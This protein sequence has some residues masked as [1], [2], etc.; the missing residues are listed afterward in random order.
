MRDLCQR[1]DQFARWAEDV[2]PPVLFWLSGFTF[3]NGF[4]AAVLQSTARQQRISVDTLSWEFIVSTVDDRNLLTPPEDGVY[5]RGLYLEGAGWDRKNSCLVEAEPMQMV[6][7]FP[8]IYFKPVE[9][10]KM[11]KSMYMCPC[12]YFPVRAGR[13]GRPSFVVGIELR[14][15]DVAP[16]HWIKRGTA[17]LLSLDN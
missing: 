6:C 15:G 16:D 9:N 14:S 10:R 3:P 5:V 4:L 2:Q 12:Y 17:L 13:A 1:V 7:P 11:S 8:T